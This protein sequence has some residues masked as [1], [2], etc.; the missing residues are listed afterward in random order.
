MGRMTTKLLRTKS[1]PREGKDQI[2]ASSARSGVEREDKVRRWHTVHATLTR[3]RP[4]H[5]MPA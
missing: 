2:C 3:V 1:P 4:A 5:A